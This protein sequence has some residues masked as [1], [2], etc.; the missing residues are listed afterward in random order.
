[1][2]NLN[3]FN[4]TC[5]SIRTYNLVLEMLRTYSFINSTNFYWEFTR[6]NQ[7][8]STQLLQVHFSIRSKD[9]VV[10][11]MIEWEEK[12]K[13]N[14]MDYRVRAQLQNI[15]YAELIK[16]N[17]FVVRVKCLMFLENVGFASVVPLTIN[18]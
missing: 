7:E 8:I 13:D 14:I 3:A 12:K 16:F 4:I 10:D 1:M 11:K 2:N 6:R 15:W 18:I 17:C 5:F 9:G